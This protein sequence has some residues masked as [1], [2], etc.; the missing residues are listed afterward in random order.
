MSRLTRKHKLIFAI[1]VILALPIASY[2]LFR[3]SQQAILIATG[4]LILAALGLW[5][6]LDPHSDPLGPLLGRRKEM[7]FTR[8]ELLVRR[9]EMLDAVENSWVK[10]VLNNALHLQLAAEMG[11]APAT[12][13]GIL[14]DGLVAGAIWQDDR[15]RLLAHIDVAAIF[16]HE[17]DRQ[18]LIVGQPGSGKTFLMLQLCQALIEQARREP[19]SRIPVVFNLSSWQPSLTLAEWLIA[20]LQSFYRVPSAQARYWVSRGTYLLPLLDGLD[21]IADLAQRQQCVSAINQ[22]QQG[23]WPPGR[24]LPHLGISADGAGAQPAHR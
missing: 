18:L 4:S 5:R 23:Q 20:E 13:G 12:L 3:S 6:L 2:L 16:Q 14:F 17:A 8:E 9:D 21:E 10:P 1:L 11:L 15:E 24:L 19:P 22:F 7:T